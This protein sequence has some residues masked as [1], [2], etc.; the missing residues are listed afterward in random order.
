MIDWVTMLCT[1]RKELPCTMA[2][3]NDRVTYIEK[4]KT[5]LSG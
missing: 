5:H 4:S 3:G 1:E 2:Y